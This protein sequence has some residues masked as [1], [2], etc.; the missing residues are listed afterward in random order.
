MD[1][2][3][4]YLSKPMIDQGIIAKDLPALYRY[5]TLYGL[6]TIVQAFAVFGFI[7]TVSLLGEQI[8]FDL[9]RS[10]F[11]HLQDLSLSFYSRTPV[12]WI[13]ARVT[14][15]PI[16]SP[17][18]SRGDCSILPGLPLTFFSRWWPC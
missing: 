13:M 2:V 14:S 1:A 9:R 6:L 16:V 3:F 18:W 15:T 11:N 8:R 5:M 17:T 12:G 10:M 4:T 7:Y